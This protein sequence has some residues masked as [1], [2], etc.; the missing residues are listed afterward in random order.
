[1]STCSTFMLI[2]TFN[3]A[4]WSVL[5]SPTSRTSLAPRTSRSHVHGGKHYRA[6][7][8]RENGV[9]CPHLA[10]GH[11]KR[12]IDD[13]LPDGE[14]DRAV[15]QDPKANIKRGRFDRASP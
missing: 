6:P 11:S 8:V 5:Y 4:T 3:G 14:A 2:P 7:S 13:K 9:A 15:C 1:M 10:D 12:R